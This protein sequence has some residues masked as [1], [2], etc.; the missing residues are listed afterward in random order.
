M[1]LPRQ[2]TPR[3]T[4]YMKHLRQLATFKATLYIEYF[5]QHPEK[6]T[7]IQRAH[8]IPTPISIYETIRG[9]HQR[10]LALR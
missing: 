9:L 3:T 5:R 8:P 4:G 7:R 2:L 1:S 6:G 10:H